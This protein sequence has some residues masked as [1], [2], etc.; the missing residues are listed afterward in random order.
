[1]AVLPLERDLIAW[2]L[3]VAA[4]SA[5]ARLVATVRTQGRAD[6]LNMEL[7]GRISAEIGDKILGLPGTLPPLP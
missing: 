4:P 7:F 6:S 5:F 2:G 3:V 1:M